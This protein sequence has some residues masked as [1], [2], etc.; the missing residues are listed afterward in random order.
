MRRAVLDGP[1][2]MRIETCAEP[3]ARPGEALVDV[4]RCGIC[5]S[6]IHSYLGRHPLVIYPVTP[7]HEFSGVVAGVGEGVDEGMVGTRV[8][9]EPSLTCGRCPQCISGRY[10]ICEDLKVMGFQA[11][12]AF[13]GRVA[14]PAEKLHVLPAEVP[15]E[16]G[17]LAEPLAVGSMPWRGPGRAPAGRSSSSG[18][19][20]SV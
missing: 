4:M 14:V 13:C 5:G 10:N 12:G 8:C 7:G 3:E 19:G 18:P 20:S 9:V 1:G 17:A 16:A 11:P 15:F 6:D 2:E